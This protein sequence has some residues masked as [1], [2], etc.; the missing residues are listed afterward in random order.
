MYYCCCYY[1]VIF[2]RVGD[3]H[4]IML[5]PG[6]PGLALPVRC[7][8]SFWLCSLAPHFWLL[9][10]RDDQMAMISSLA[11][12]TDYLLSSH[13]LSHWGMWSALPGLKINL[14][15]NMW[16]FIM[17][18]IAH[19]GSNLVIC[20]AAHIYSCTANGIVSTSGPRT[21]ILW[22]CIDIL[23]ET[24]LGKPCQPWTVQDSGKVRSNFSFLLLQIKHSFFCLLVFF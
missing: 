23:S 8:D 15:F 12:I 21:S 1:F 24:I 10:G 22:H 18:K 20:Y 16:D 11:C 7:D 5:S 14:H 13:L 9:M 17:Q 4:F 19:M 6:V 2:V 3:A